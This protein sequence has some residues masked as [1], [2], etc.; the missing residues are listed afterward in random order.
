MG[1]RLNSH[2]IPDDKLALTLSG[3]KESGSKESGSKDMQAISLQHFKKL[4]N[5][6]GIPEF[7]TLKT[8]TDTVDA[9]RR[10][11]NTSAYTDILPVEMIERID[12]HMR[13]Q[14]LF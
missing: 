10:H 7:I 11:L 1:E 8:V 9:V 12:R 6:A 13:A 5:K 2:Y 3:S 4:A 14:A